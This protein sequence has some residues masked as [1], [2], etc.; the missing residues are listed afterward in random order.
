MKLL[1]LQC[2]LPPPLHRHRRKKSEHRP[3]R[4]NRCNKP[5]QSNKVGIIY[6]KIES[7]SDTIH[8]Q[9]Q[10]NTKKNH[11]FNRDQ[12]DRFGVYKKPVKV[13][14]AKL[15]ESHR[16]NLQSFLRDISYCVPKQK[17]YSIE[18]Y[19]KRDKGGRQAKHAQIAIFLSS[20]HKAIIHRVFY[21]PIYPAQALAEERANSG[22]SHSVDFSIKHV[23]N[24][25]VLGVHPQRHFKVFGAM[26]VPKEAN[27]IKD[28]AAV[29]RKRP[30]GNIL[31][32]HTRQYLLKEN[33]NSVFSILHPLNHCFWLKYLDG[34]CDRHHGRVIE[35]MG[36]AAKGT[37]LHK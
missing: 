25:Q 21:K 11:T 2:N 7:S 19:D 23:F 35:N 30:G 36:N 24:A 28:R 22:R 20:N 3:R 17:E 5:I 18:E 9:H 12:R 4:P 31:R 34:R 26:C 27:L 6:F 29:N 10:N 33:S 16:C 15:W 8:S 14:V 32:V 13:Y 1:S 37:R